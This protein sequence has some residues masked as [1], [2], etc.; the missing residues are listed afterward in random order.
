ML[1]SVRVVKVAVCV[2]LAALTIC[3]LGVTRSDA[4]PVVLDK[5][6]KDNLNVETD[7]LTDDELPELLP[8]IG[9]DAVRLQVEEEI[10]RRAHKWL[11]EG[12]EEVAVAHMGEPAAEPERAV[13]AHVGE[14]APEQEAAAVYRLIRVTNNATGDVI[15]TDIGEPLAG[16]LVSEQWED[17]PDGIIVK[18]GAPFL[19][20]EG[21]LEIDSLTTAELAWATQHAQE[22]SLKNRLMME[23]LQRGVSKDKLSEI[24][25]QPPATIRGMLEILPTT[26]MEEIHL[27]HRKD[28]SAA[29]RAM[30]D[31]A[32][33]RGNSQFFNMG[34]FEIQA[35]SFRSPRFRLGF[36]SLIAEER[37]ESALQRTDRDAAEHWAFYCRLIREVSRGAPLTHAI[38]D[39]T[40]GR[41][42][43]MESPIERVNDEAASLDVV[44]PLDGI[45]TEQRGRWEIE[46]EELVARHLG[47]AKSGSDEITHR[48]T[49]V[50]KRRTPP[51]NGSFNSTVRGWLKK[52]CTCCN[53][54]KSE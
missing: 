36:I 39:S 2:V 38:V 37:L 46:A 29:M 34:I 24:S 35:S 13:A 5:P 23:L 49:Y 17:T 20:R 10:D 31:A 21:E 45:T 48:S 50:S 32:K 28:P 47:P 27:R 41:T 15:D 26:E 51:Q 25:K 1:V 4:F 12:P 33:A 9:D 11:K 43:M 42:Q 54:Q 22:N 16:S 6:F 19:G 44:L 7:D 53:R 3:F 14:P 30:E 52:N 8:L 40:W 18:L